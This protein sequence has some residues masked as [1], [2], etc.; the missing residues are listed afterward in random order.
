MFGGT[1][2][3]EARAADKLNYVPPKAGTITLVD[4]GSIAK[5]KLEPLS[6]LAE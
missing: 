2:M 1:W 3:T 5:K 6:P 4:K